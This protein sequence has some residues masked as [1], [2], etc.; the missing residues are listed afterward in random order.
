[1]SVTAPSLHRKCKGE[2]KEVKEMFYRLVFLFLVLLPFCS[3]AQQTARCR[4]VTKRYFNAV[5]GYVTV[6]PNLSQRGKRDFRKKVARLAK[7]KLRVC[8][9]D[10]AFRRKSRHLKRLLNSLKTE[11]GSPSASPSATPSL[12]GS[13]CDSTDLD[14]N[15][16]IDS[17][18]FLLF[19]T[20][21]SEQRLA[22]DLTQD[23]RLDSSDFL[24]FASCFEAD[25]AEG[26]KGH[27][28]IMREAVKRWSEREGGYSIPM[29]IAARCQIA[30]FR[31]SWRGGLSNTS[32]RL[33]SSP[34]SETAMCC[35]CSEKNMYP[36]LTEIQMCT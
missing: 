34:S 3:N 10:A 30:D 19:L 17:D 29:Q 18:D 25:L 24:F 11:L 32:L 15:K 13:T 26:Q 2:F 36:S 14:R 23:G 4:E 28:R 20:L 21:Y 7:S 1:M 33:A 27:Q 22:A 5:E 16:Q 9:W 12:T 31:L 6:Y 8:P 35:V